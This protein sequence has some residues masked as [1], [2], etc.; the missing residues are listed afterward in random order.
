MGTRSGHSRALAGADT[1]TGRRQKTRD[2]IGGES[3]HD[4]PVTTVT[5]TAIQLE[6]FTS[7]H[8]R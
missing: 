6:A 4:S 5:A 7:G 1:K 3:N 8:I 2:E